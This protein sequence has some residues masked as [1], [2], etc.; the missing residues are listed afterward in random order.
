MTHHASK[1]IY[2]CDVAYAYR[3]CVRPGFDSPHLHHIINR[4]RVHDENMMAVFASP[5]RE[6]GRR[7]AVTGT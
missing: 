6:V 3:G 5:I 7:E 4:P 2:A 1:R